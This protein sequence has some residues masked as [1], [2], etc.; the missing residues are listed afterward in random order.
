MQGGYFDKFEICDLL[1]LGLII[2][3]HA[4]YKYIK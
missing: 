3:I 1:T 4:K 2:I